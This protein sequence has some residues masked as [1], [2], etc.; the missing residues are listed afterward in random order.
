[1]TTSA[2]GEQRTL[3]GLIATKLGAMVFVFMAGV[4]AAR[5]LGAS[6]KG[7]V[8]VAL[9]LFAL[10]LLLAPSIE[11]P[12]LILLAKEP[13]AAGRLAVNGLVLALVLGLLVLAVWW[14]VFRSGSGVV[15][16]LMPRSGSESAP[17]Q[18]LWLMLTAPCE[19][20][21]RLLAGVLQGRR[22]MRSFMLVVLIRHAV[23]LAAMLLLVLGLDLGVTG[24]VQA[25]ALGAVSAA[26]S[27]AW[28]VFRDEE[29]RAT[30]LGCDLR[31]MRLQIGGGLRA[32]GAVVAVAVILNG[33]Q[34]ILWQFHGAASVGIYALAAAITGQLRR[35]MV[36]PVKELLGSQVQQTAHDKEVLAEAIT[37]GVRRVLVLLL[38][39]SL[40]LALVIW[41][42][43]LL[44]YGEAFL[45][46]AEPVWILLPGGLFWAVAVVLSWWFMGQNRF[47]VLTLAALAIAAVNVLLNVLLIPTHGAL[48]AAWTSTLCYAL[49]ALLFAAAFLAGSGRGVAAL[50]P[51][52]REFRALWTK[53]LAAV[54][55]R[56]ST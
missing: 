23:V 4:V 18:L 19:I 15:A 32:Q 34:L 24:A 38:P 27:A 12:Q 30:G 35:L 41:P 1:M 42:A 20:L 21:S 28:F 2:A 44:V 3:L 55:G 6:G 7:E 25:W 17:P 29:L 26:A 8:D 5:T 48:A 16:V 53:P 56:A 52:A 40:L 46:A 13:S 43:L 36:Q 31:L 54:F 49:H 22:R 47:G 50:W 9:G 10:L 14:G 39:P 51:E 11:E 37:R 33:D 45:G